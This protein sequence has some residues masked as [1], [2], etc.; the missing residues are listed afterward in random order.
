[1]YETLKGSFGSACMTKE[2]LEVCYCVTMLMQH[3]Y[4]EHKSIRPCIFRATTDVLPW[5]ND[6]CGSLRWMKKKKDQEEE[7]AL[8]RMGLLGKSCGLLLIPLLN[9]F[10]VHRYCRKPCS[11]AVLVLVSIAS[12]T[13]VFANEVSFN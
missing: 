7:F 4:A 5:A 13:T 3:S 6:S 1:M 9:M 10:L 2:A 12:V 8:R 11:V